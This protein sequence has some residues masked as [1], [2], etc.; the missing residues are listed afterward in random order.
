MSLI[1]KKIITNKKKKCRWTKKEKHQKCT[2]KD[3]K[4]TK[5]GN[6]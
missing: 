3:K 5:E 1:D 4:K 2:E 6:L